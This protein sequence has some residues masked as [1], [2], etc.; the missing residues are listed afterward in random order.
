MP[1][2]QHNRRRFDDISWRIL[3]WLMDALALGLI[4]VT[5]NLHLRITKLELWQAETA[6]NRYTSQ[7]HARYAE[8]QARELTRLWAAQAD[9]QK[10]WL[11]D[12]GDIKAAI[13]K[14]PT[15]SPP[16]WFVDYVR[17]RNAD[18]DERVKRLEDKK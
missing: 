9:M 2:E 5:V 4:A 18:L 14:L 3:G 13:A 17:E 6:G 11:V 16:Q 7:D 10:K 8:E 12:I 15:E 1:D